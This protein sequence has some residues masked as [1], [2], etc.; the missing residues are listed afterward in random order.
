V[1]AN[2]VAAIEAR[3]GSQIAFARVV[4][5]HPVRLNRLC[6]GWLEPTPIE[7]DRIAEALG[8]DADWLFSAFRLP[9]PK[10]GATSAERA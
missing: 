5:L 8:V 9:A 1:K 4:G 7:R 6:R 10:A 2:L 3:F